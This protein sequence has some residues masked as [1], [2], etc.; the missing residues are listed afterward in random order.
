MMVVTRKVATVGTSVCDLQG[1]FPLYFSLRKHVADLSL[2]EGKTRWK[3]AGKCHPPP[4]FNPVFLHF[5]QPAMVASRVVA[6]L[7][8]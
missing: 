3:K 2:R 6:Q 1:N 8:C 7:P 4:A 5:A